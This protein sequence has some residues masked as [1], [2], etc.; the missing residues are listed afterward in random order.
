MVKYTLKKQFDIS[1]KPKK[2]NL[3]EFSFANPI[4]ES[5]VSDHE[6]KDTTSTGSS[7]EE[8]GTEYQKTSTQAGIGK[9]S[10]SS[11]D[12]DDEAGGTVI[13]HGPKKI[14]EKSQKEIINYGS[15]NLEDDSTNNLF[16]L[17]ATPG[18]TPGGGA[19]DPYDEIFEEN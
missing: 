14:E 18:E 4:E 6:N 9:E 2:K 3:D 5:K 15:S 19:K 13:K 17:M 8:K 7:S 10:S 11:Q 1:H 12:G 16:D